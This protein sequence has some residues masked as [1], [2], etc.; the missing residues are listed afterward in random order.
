MQKAAA[1][2]AA[3][4]LATGALARAQNAAS[5]S[6]RPAPPPAQKLK[7]EQAVREYLSKLPPEQRKKVM[8]AL[9]EVWEDAEVKSARQQLKDSAENY[10]R[11]MAEAVADLAPEVRDIVRPLVERVVRD[12]L[13]PPGLPGRKLGVDAPPRFLR[14][15]GLTPERFDGLPTGD[16]ALIISLREKVMS[17]SRVRDAAVRLNQAEGPP[18]K[19]AAWRELRRTARQVAVDL[20]PRLDSILQKVGESLGP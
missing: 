1:I 5:E 20:E 9:K 16:K 10:K 2:L 13:T 8:A 19:A 11:T 3:G 12:G 6:P 7:R 14:S 17:D 18:Q 4:V 15:L